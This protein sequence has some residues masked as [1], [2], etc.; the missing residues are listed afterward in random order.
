MDRYE[1][2]DKAKECEKEEAELHLVNFFKS[3]MPKQRNE[4]WIHLAKKQSQRAYRDS[5]KLEHLL[6]FSLSK[7]IEN[8]KTLYKYNNGVYW[9]FKDKPILVSAEEAFTLGYYQD[10]IYSIEPGKKAIF[11]Y[12]EGGAW[13]FEK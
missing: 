10:G 9:D 4:R 12:H 13:L 2:F 11:F 5:H 6:D 1:I 3:F 8:E 7:E